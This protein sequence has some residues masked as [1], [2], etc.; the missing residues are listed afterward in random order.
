MF[1]ATT[2]VFFLIPA[3]TVMP[4]QSQVYFLNVTFAV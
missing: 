1:I 3:V 2:S 4:A